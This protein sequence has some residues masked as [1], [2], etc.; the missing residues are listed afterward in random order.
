MGDG[1]GGV[2][3]APEGT[4]SVEVDFEEAEEGRVDQ[5]GEL[6]GDEV[7][8]E[9]FHGLHVAAAVA[10]YSGD[11]LF[12]QALVEERLDCTAFPRTHCPHTHDHSDHYSPL[13][14]LSE[15]S[16]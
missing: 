5:A 13:H 11:R 14:R 7:G 1:E 2:L 9:V 10:D 16:R 4:V 3:T 12:T 6:G 15:I 8:V